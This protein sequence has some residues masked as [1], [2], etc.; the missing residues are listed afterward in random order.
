M[1]SIPTPSNMML[2]HFILLLQLQVAHPLQSLVFEG[3]GVRGTVY[4][5]AVVA[6]E[7]AGALA[8]I[9]NFAGTSAGSSAAAMLAVG[10]TACE[11]SN[12][13]MVQS[14]ADLVEFSLFNRVKLAVLG[15]GTSALANLLGRQKGF[16]SGR[17]LEDAADI[18]IAK[19]LCSIDLNISFSSITQDDL[20]EERDATAMEGKCAFYRRASFGLLND[21]NHGSK[22]LSI[23]SFDITN[24]TL[25]Y[26]NVGT[27]ADMAISKAIR[28]SS[29]IPLIF[30]PVEYK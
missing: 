3:G 29:S 24:G 12:E 21:L 18:A 4:A 27:A 9:H 5:G 22:K 14:F 20:K 17:S 15:S 23:S 25:V 8:Q 6:L 7:E 2:V 16:F 13:V 28:M 11:F 19:K 10:Y 30:E 1:A 26:F